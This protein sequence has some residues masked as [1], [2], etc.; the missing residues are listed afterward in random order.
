MQINNYNI[1]FVDD[2]IYLLDL[3]KKW[4]DKYFTNHNFTFKNEFSCKDILN[5]NYDI[6][7]C[8]YYL[9]GVTPEKYIKKIREFNDKIIILVISGSL[10]I[11]CFKTSKCYNNPLLHEVIRNGANNVCEKDINKILELLKLHISVRNN[12]YQS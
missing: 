2:D 6:L 1:L 3:F 12:N 9:N 4:C 8:D 10:V 7:V 11:D 5:G